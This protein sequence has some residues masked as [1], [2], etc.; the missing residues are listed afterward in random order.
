M[1]CP[2]FV[3][4]CL[5]LEY[6][7]FLFCNAILGL[8][9]INERTTP[10]TGKS[11]YTHKRLR[12]A[13]FSLKSNTPWLFTYQE[14]ENKG[15]PNSSN[16]LEGLFSHLKSCLRNH[17]GINEDSKTKLIDGFFEAFCAKK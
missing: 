14:P 17:N 5:V 16:K 10:Q 4:K 3:C 9:I 1:I 2:L 6:R 8:D 11:F 13:Y 12:S 7:Y 15:M